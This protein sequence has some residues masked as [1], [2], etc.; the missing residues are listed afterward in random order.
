MHV[1]DRLVACLHVH[2][3]SRHPH[4]V[5][6]D[7]DVCANAFSLLRRTNC[8]GCTH[9]RDQQPTVSIHA[10]PQP[11][12]HECCVLSQQCV[13][14]EPDARR[15]SCPHARHNQRTSQ[16]HVSH[17]RGLG[18]LNMQPAAPRR[19]AH[20]LH[21]GLAMQEGHVGLWSAQSAELGMGDMW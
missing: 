21:R 8:A 5:V 9:V 15:T 19:Q 17:A 20:W 18:S 14:Y 2:V 7:P 6:C 11:P 16:T 10:L 3:T 4:T 1:A 12:W 13:S